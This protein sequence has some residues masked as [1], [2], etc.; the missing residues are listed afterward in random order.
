MKKPISK[1]EDRIESIG[2]FALTALSFL[3]F[4]APM[5]GVAEA[6]AAAAWASRFSFGSSSLSTIRTFRS[7]PRT[8]NFQQGVSMFQTVAAAMALP[9]VG[10]GLAQNPVSVDLL[11]RTLLGFHTTLAGVSLARSA[12]ELSRLRSSAESKSEEGKKQI[13]ATSVELGTSAVGLFLGGLGVRE[14]FFRGGEDNEFEISR[15]Y[16]ASHFS[17][18]SSR[19]GSVG[20]DFLFGSPRGSPQAESPPI[21]RGMVSFADPPRTPST[22]FSSPRPSPTLSPV[23]EEVSPTVGVM[24][25]TPPASPLSLSPLAPVGV[26][27]RTPPLSLSLSP[28]APVEEIPPE[29]HIPSSSSSPRWRSGSQEPLLSPP[30]TTGRR[31]PYSIMTDNMTYYSARGTRF[32]NEAIRERGFLGVQRLSFGL[33]LTKGVGEVVQKGVTVDW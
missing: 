33:E 13:A 27:P 5:V 4:V 24:P 18:G 14:E 1:T 15:G 16:A 12:Q 8:P 11:R 7:S 29:I 6:G 17:R 2:A 26:A 28:L 31:T 9:L 20:S 25:H 21:R 3:S 10:R 23:G 30:P 32:Y 19:E 22:P